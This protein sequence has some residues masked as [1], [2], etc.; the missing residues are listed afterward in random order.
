MNLGWEPTYTSIGS[1]N[2][3]MKTKIMSLEWAPSCI[4]KDSTNKKTKNTTMSLRWALA[5]ISKGKY[6]TNKKTK[7][8]AKMSKWKT[9]VER[10]TQNNKNAKM[11]SLDGDT[12]A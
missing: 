8:I 9:R 5:C 6:N 4:S 12:F 3:K 10:N 11:E 1:T 7:I 2:K